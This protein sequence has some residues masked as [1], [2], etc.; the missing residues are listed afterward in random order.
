MG[1]ASS[2]FGAAGVLG[3]QS[4]NVFDSFAGIVYTFARF[5]DPLLTRSLSLPG[6]SYALSEYGDC[7]VRLYDCQ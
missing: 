7:R 5:N 2:Q 6:E 3:G 1:L 4:S